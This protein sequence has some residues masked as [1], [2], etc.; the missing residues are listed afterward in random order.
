M[1]RNSGVPQEL[2]DDEP[3]ATDTA[4][5]ASSAD[6]GGGRSAGAPDAGAAA[7]G[8][9]PS[10]LLSLQSY[11]DVSDAGSQ[12]GESPRAG[13]QPPQQAGM[14]AASSQAADIPAAG[15]GGEGRRE[16]L[17]SMGSPVSSE[18]RLGGLPQGVHGP[19]AGTCSHTDPAGLP[20]KGRAEAAAGAS[21]G[22]AGCAAPSGAAQARAAGLEQAL[23]GPCD[24]AAALREAGPER[25]LGDEPSARSVADGG[26]GLLDGAAAGPPVWQQGVLAVA[27]ADEGDQEAHEHGPAGGAAAGGDADGLTLASAPAAS[28]AAVECM[29]AYGPA[30]MEPGGRSTGAVAA[31]E[32]AAELNRSEGGSI[33]IACAES[34]GALGQGAAAAAAAA[35]SSPG[36]DPAGNAAPVPAAP[37]ASTPEG[38][39]AV[40]GPGRSLPPGRAA[41]APGVAV[42]PV[43]DARDAGS[44][45]QAALEVSAGQWTGGGRAQLPAAA[46]QAAAGGQA[47]ESARAGAGGGGREAGAGGAA[48][49]PPEVRAIIAKLAPF[50]QVRGAGGLLFSS[51]SCAGAGPGAGARARL[52]APG[53]V[54]VPWLHQPWT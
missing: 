44:A 47:G 36:A 49:P 19:P 48:L 38:A 17:G 26:S 39:G 24:A 25:T 42:Q 11:A 15:P 20:G 53:R 4:R 54:P 27:V 29:P 35:E 10:A 34:R 9:G 28:A 51:A 2:P 12:E 43:A 33:V 1:I 32:D 6:D 52:D 3:Q 23:D 16:P 45:V 21:L 31:P 40:T 30:L 22:A 14:S 18:D 8:A 50:I 46:P 7:A 5:P 41:A 13:P 37:V